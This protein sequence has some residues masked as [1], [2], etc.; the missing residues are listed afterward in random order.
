MHVMVDC[1]TLSLRTNAVIVSIG[2]VAF[3]PM[4]EDT[5]ESLKYGGRTLHIPLDMVKQARIGRHIDPGT[6][7]WW[8]EQSEEARR[9]LIDIQGDP[10]KKL[11]LKV[12][13]VN[14]ARFIEHYG[15]GDV[16]VW[17]NGAADDISWIR[18]LADDIGVSRKHLF[19]HRCPRDTRTLF[20]MAGLYDASGNLPD[21]EGLTKHDALSDAIYQALMV[22][23]AYKR[24]TRFLME[25]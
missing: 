10:Y 13:T 14:L 8:L 21:V 24:I 16:K 12:A 1:E 15:G 4:A 7:L 22:Q 18:S 9:S 23:R 25:K 17:A 6:V 3:D 2:A 5:V 11:D 19:G 20:D